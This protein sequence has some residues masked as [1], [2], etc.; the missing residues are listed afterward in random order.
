ML[1]CRQLSTGNCRCYLSF[2][3]CQRYLLLKNACIFAWGF[4]ITSNEICC[5]FSLIHFDKP[6]KMF[7]LYFIRKYTI[8]CKNVSNENC[9]CMWLNDNCYWLLSIEKSM[10]IIMDFFVVT[11]HLCFSSSSCFLFYTRSLSG[12]VLLCFVL[13]VPSSSF[14]SHIHFPQY[15]LSPKYTEKFAGYQL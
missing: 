1:L 3:K 15:L 11:R 7:R 2:D 6:L 4:V 10:R 13:L 9:P 14:G 5:H 8:I 12:Y